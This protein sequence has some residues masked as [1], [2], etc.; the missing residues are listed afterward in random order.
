[1]QVSYCF[2]N[3]LMGT[4]LT[5]KY[6]EG[7]GVFRSDSVTTLA[8]LKEVRVAAMACF[9]E[10]KGVGRECLV[11]SLLILSAAQTGTRA[12]VAGSGA[13]TIGQRLTPVQWRAD[14]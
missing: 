2:Q 8:I 5:C 12:L 9:W 13:R 3:V 6:R 10:V 7:E 11:Y 1:M 14:S 4:F